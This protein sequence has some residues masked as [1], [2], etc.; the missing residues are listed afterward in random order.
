MQ[1]EQFDKRNGTINLAFAQL[2]G[3]ADE[4]TCGLV[5]ASQASRDVEKLWTVLR[6]YKYVVWETRYENA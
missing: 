5:A 6:V 1:Q 3:T 4:L 2:M